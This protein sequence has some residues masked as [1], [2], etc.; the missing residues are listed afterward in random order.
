[1]RGNPYV[2]GDDAPRA[3]L[4]IFS[5]SE[6][7]PFT[8]GS[9]RMDFAEAVLAQPIA[10]RVI[11]NRIWRW[12]M[13]TGIVDT[14]NNFGVAGD[15]PSNPELLDYLASQFVANGMSWKKLTKQIVMSRTYRLSSAPSEENT[16]K[17]ANNRYYWRANRR[18]LEAEGIWDGLLMASGKLDMK[19]IGGPSEELDAK[20]TRRGA[21][22]VVSRVFPNEF[23]SLFDYPIPTLSAERRYT[24]NVALQQLFFLNND[25]VR[26][27]AEALA[28]RARAAGPEG[29]QVSKAFEI[30]YQ[31]EPSASEMAAALEVL[32]QPDPDLQRAAAPMKAAAF[33]AKPAP[34]PGTLASASVNAPG[35]SSKET[36]LQAL[37]W[38]LLSSNEFLFLN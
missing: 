33:A 7:K 17:D 16:A 34:G 18:R 6:P 2:F 29:A 32:H 38:A 30:V 15:R 27:Q 3:F 25:F 23:Q 35:G 20:M 11:V 13:G 10:M 21:Y 5:E 22:G 26:Q 31:R 28:A 4:S 19:T 37:C 9:G 24:T 1:V 36:P 8:H 14:P 12:H